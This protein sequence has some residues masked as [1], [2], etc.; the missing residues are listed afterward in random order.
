MSFP[1]QSARWH[2]AAS[3]LVI[4]TAAAPSIFG[5]TNYVT[6]TDTHHTRTRLWAPTSEPSSELK[7]R[8]WRDKVVVL[9]TII[10]WFSLYNFVIIKNA[11][12]VK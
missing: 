3:F 11:V 7:M 4:S 8:L 2:P 12:V 10:V 6:R 9:F 5:T 1:G